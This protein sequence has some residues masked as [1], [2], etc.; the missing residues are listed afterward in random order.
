[1]NA[2]LL[3]LSWKEKNIVIIGL[4]RTRL[5]CAG[6]CGRGQVLRKKYLLVQNVVE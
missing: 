4:S 1:M 5:V 2:I 6:E 3:I